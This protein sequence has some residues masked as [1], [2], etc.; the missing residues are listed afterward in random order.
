[1]IKVIPTA[2]LLSILFSAA[3]CKAKPSAP[4]P[5][6][7]PELATAIPFLG[8]VVVQQ[9]SDEDHAIPGVLFDDATL[10]KSAREQIV[11]AGVFSNPQVNQPSVIKPKADVLLGYIAEDV[12]AEG[13]ALARVV[14]KLKVGIKPANAADPD[15]AE[16]V[17]AS[18]EM[19]YTLGKEGKPSPKAFVSLVTKLNADL[20]G[21]YL[22]RQKLRTAP[23][24]AIVEMIKAD[25]E[26]TLRE[27]AIRQ[28]G[29]RKL[30]MA[31][32]PLLGLLTNDSEP[33][34]DAAL[35]ALL[36]MREQRAVS[37]LAAS[38]SMRDR[39]E[40]RKIVE[41]IALLGGSEAVSYLEFV[42][43]ANEDDEI[44]G[45]AKRSLERLRKR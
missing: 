43:D 31:V 19:P 26:T 22:A 1:M 27:A 42:A 4:E 21:E 28:A 29:Q 36:Q 25:D 10:T 18:G 5:S 20:L 34:R 39:R 40:M 11:A 14:A 24:Q 12:R 33:I 37:V 9:M 45:L 16:D 30:A 7:V 17:E 32:D 6:R 13:K 44:R 8:Q 38:R 23:E 2:L 3:A 35:G 15:W 41:A